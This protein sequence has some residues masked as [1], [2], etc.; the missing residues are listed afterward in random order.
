MV[1]RLYVRHNI[2][3][4]GS[5]ALGQGFFER[6]GA[7]N[8]LGGNSFLFMLDYI[9]HQQRFRE[10]QKIANLSGNHLF[11]V[12]FAHPLLKCGREIFND[13]NSFRP[14]IMQ[15]MLELTRGVERINIHHHIVGP[16]NTS[17]AKSVHVRPE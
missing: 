3:G 4:E 7:E 17:M 10:P 14:A 13:H 2:A 9:V 12:G 11:D 5:A 6:N 8:I 15:L 1:T 16:Q